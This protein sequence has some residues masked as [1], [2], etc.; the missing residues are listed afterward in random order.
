MSEELKTKEM[1]LQKQ[2]FLFN[3]ALIDLPEL[4][5]IE[6]LHMLAHASMNYHH[7]DKSVDT[8]EIGKILQREHGIDAIPPRTEYEC[9]AGLWSILRKKLMAESPEQE[10]SE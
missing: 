8:W 2:I 1:F 4:L 6:C 7:A 10:V 9:A 5:P 3:K